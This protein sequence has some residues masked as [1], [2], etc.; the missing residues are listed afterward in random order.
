[1]EK[2][3]ILAADDERSL[4]VS[5]KNVLTDAGYTVAV[6]S[7]REEFLA[8]LASFNPDVDFARHLSWSGERHPDFKADQI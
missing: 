1:M 4:T 6:S 3:R 2:G 7:N 5:V 8:Q